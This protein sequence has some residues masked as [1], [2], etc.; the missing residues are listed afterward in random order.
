MFG[1]FGTG[2]SFAYAAFLAFAG[3]GCSLLMASNNSAWIKWLLRSLGIIPVI[4]SGIMLAF[5][6]FGGGDSV[7]SLM[8][9]LPI[10]QGIVIGLLLG[11][12]LLS[13][14]GWEHY[15]KTKRMNPSEGQ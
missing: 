12:V 3:V 10:G 15:V 7:A 5:L 2:I 8:R 6:H 9:L 13:C 14:L 4:L 1:L 11:V